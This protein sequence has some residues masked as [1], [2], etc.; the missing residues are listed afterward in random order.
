MGAVTNSPISIGRTLGVGDFLPL[1]H[2][3][4]RLRVDVRL[5]RDFPFNRLYPD[6]GVRKKPMVR[7]ITGIDYRRNPN[8]SNPA[9]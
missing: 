8:P 6:L 4:S 3:A 1:V 9:S 7:D 5:N 2:P